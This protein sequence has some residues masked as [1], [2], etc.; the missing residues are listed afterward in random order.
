MKKRFGIMVLAISLVATFAAAQMPGDYLGPLGGGDVANYPTNTSLGYKGVVMANFDPADAA[1]EIAADFGSLG[2]WYFNDGVW[3]QLSGINPEGLISART[4]DPGAEELVADFGPIGLWYWDGLGWLQLSGVNPEGLIAVDDDGGGTDEIQV[5]FGAVGLWRYQFDAETWTQYS[6]LNPTKGLRTDL[7]P[8]GIEEGTWIF[9]TAGIWSLWTTPGGGVGFRQ[10]SGTFSNEDGFASGHFIDSTG[11]EDLVAD[12]GA[13]GLWLC[14]GADASWVQISGLNVKRVREVK[15]S[16]PEERLVIDDGAGQLFWGEWNGS[17][18]TW[19][20]IVGPAITSILTGPNWCEPFDLYAWDDG[21]EE[22]LIPL[23]A[24]GAYLFD[25]SLNRNLKE[26]INSYYLV[27]FAVKGDYYGTGRDSTLAVVFGAS[28]FEP[29]LWLHENES[30]PAHW[31]WLKISAAI[32]DG[33][34]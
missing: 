9:E 24:G 14:K 17:G 25:Y 20:P 21:D 7:A 10:L 6:G 13:S 31:G 8:A 30:N 22:V 34:Y 26:F 19:N 1:D 32:P 29:G 28:S 5:D 33:M 12:F 3:V 15:F 23:A 27:N 18:M 4:K 16:E 2:L 11:A